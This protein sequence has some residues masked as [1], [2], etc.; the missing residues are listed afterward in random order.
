MS[1]QLATFFIICAVILG[2]GAL[3]YLKFRQP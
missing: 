3:L 1:W 2:G